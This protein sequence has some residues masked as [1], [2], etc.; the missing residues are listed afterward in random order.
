MI[1]FNLLKNISET[2]GA[3][4]FENPIR[5]LV[6]NEITGLCDSIEV[7]NMGNIIAFKKGKSSDKKLMLAAH[8]D[9]IAFIVT[10]IDEKGFLRFL[11][12]GGFDPKT[13]SSQRVIIHGKKDLIGVM[14]TKP[15]HLMSPE[16][17]GK[18]VQI[19]DYFIDLGL[20]KEEVD[21]YVEIGTPITRERQLIEMGDCLNGKS[22]DNRISVYIQIE[23]L[24]R[25][26]QPAYDTYAVFTVQE[27]VGLR[28]AIAA[29]HRINPDFGIAID[30][31]IAY[32]TPGAPAYEMVTSLGKGVAIK[33]LDGGTICDHR[34]VSY[35]K[36]LATDNNLTWQAEILPAGG[37]D[38]AAIQRNGKNG[39]I[40][41]AV[42]IPTRHIH[43]VIE[44]V[45]KKDVEAAISLLTL[46][47]ENID[48]YNWSF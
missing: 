8:L 39:S 14:G 9:E 38:T 37:T 45:H 29:T 19:K 32:D 22:L 25:L 40:A 6:L 2:P 36:K 42:S 15:V 4:G 13:L 24:K 47:C 48:T 5:N 17:R 44:S 35:M 18:G 30:T 20:E 26:K 28:G 34:M 27:E 1:N 7:D 10:H 31:T 23:A 16:E 11:P 33:I 41:G 12:L 21:K 46:C 3:P 43:Q